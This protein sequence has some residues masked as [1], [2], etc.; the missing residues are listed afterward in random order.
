[1]TKRVVTAFLLAPLVAAVLCSSITLI[2]VGFPGGWSE[3]LATILVT[4]IYAA[5]GTVVLALPTYVLLIRFD[6]VRWW[7]AL[8]AGGVLGLLFGVMIG[9]FSAPLLRGTFPLAIIGAASGLVFWLICRPVTPPNN[10]WR[11]P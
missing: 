5:A 8:A 10:R 2:S 11:G 6:L 1:M 4:Y 3:F 9:P 7:S